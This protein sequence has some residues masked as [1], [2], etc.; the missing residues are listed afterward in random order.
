[1]TAKFH[2][3]TLLFLC[4]VIMTWFAQSVKIFETSFSS[5]E[6][7]LAVSGQSLMQRHL[8]CVPDFH[9]VTKTR[10][11]AFLPDLHRLIYHYARF[12]RL[13]DL[14]E[15]IRT[16]I[17]DSDVRHRRFD[18]SSSFL[19][20]FSEPSPLVIALW[21]DHQALYDKINGHSPE[22]LQHSLSKFHLHEF[23]SYD[24]VMIL[25]VLQ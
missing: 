7:I 8:M 18:H 22:K 25:W 16:G 23:K 17:R 13:V 1:M 12:Y 11:E 20:L 3:F 6:P 9:S 2:I 21:H 4:A 24:R 15:C 14:F 10:A 5:L 19:A